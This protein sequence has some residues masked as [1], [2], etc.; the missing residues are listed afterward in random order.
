MFKKPERVVLVRHGHISPLEKGIDKSETNLMLLDFIAEEIETSMVAKEVGR[1]LFLTSPALRA[2]ET[3]DHLAVSLL[4]LQQTVDAIIETDLLG[5][6]SKL[7]TGD[8]TDA[9]NGKRAAVHEFSKFVDEE[10]VN[11]PKTGLVVVTHE[12]V[13]HAIGLIAGLES[14]DIHADSVDKITI[15]K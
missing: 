12:P 2:T 1:V 4:E 13:I 6:D 15:V 11:H 8:V 7:A 9:L 10:A 14:K 3:T 5:P